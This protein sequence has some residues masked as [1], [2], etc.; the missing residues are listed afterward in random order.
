VI[1]SLAAAAVS[2]LLCTTCVAFDPNG[3]AVPHL[4]GRYASIISVHYHN[5]LEGWWDTV[6]ATVVLPDA[7]GRGAFTGSYATADGDAGTVGGILQPDGTME[8]TEFAQPPLVTLQGA[9]FL[10][11]LY[12]WCDFEHVGTG[13]L[14]G[15]LS[16]DS[17]VIE[18]RA[19]LLCSYQ[20]WGQVI[21]VGTDLDVRLAGAR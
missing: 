2:A 9:T 4:A 6:V 12:P 15:S 21:G 18:G 17:L 20:A 10:H 19:S 8:V 3:P 1:R 11:R 14:T 16:G 5:D 13:T 7:G